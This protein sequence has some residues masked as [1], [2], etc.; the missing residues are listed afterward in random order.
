[1]QD[2]VKNFVRDC[3]GCWTCIRAASVGLPNGA[4]VDALPGD[5]FRQGELIEGIDLAR[6]MDEHAASS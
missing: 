4:R 6:L 1:M 2:F 5:R 3:S